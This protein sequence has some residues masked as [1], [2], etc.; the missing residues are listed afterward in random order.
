MIIFQ[1]DYV[2]NTTL[3]QVTLLEGGY[4]YE[5][6]VTPLVEGTKT[7]KKLLMSGELKPKK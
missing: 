2:I 7:L 5:G 6:D 4:I 1:K 3:R